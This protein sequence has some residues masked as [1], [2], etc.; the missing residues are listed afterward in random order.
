MVEVTPDADTPPAK[1]HWW[2]SM[3]FK[4][5]LSLLMLGLL[6]WTTDLSD[7]RRAIAT[8]RP[9]WAIAAL[10][11]YLASMVVSSI[12]WTM[13]ARPLGF[14]AP[15]SHFFGS[16]FTGMYMNLFAPSTVAG[17]ISR[18]LF[19]AGGPGR[20]ALALTTVI[21]DRGLG[22]VVLVW[23]G[24]IAIVLQPEYRLPLP[25]YYG[26]WVVPPATL[27]AW[28]YL[29]KL[30]VRFFPNDSRWRILVEKDLAPYW[31]DLR[32]LLA[33]SVVAFVF[34]VMQVF[35]QVLLAWSLGMDT[36]WSYFF[37]FVPIVNIVGMVPI[38]F[39]G[40]GIREFGYIFFLRKAGIVKHT[41]MALGLLASGMVIASNLFGGL[42]FLL[43]KAPAPTLEN[44][45]RRTVAGER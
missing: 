40:V 8:A 31:H 18:A 27:A 38:S 34:H 19:I 23:I 17:D 11:C 35:S 9:G 24:A 41:A 15:Y 22:F 44:S 10:L 30:V 42:V 32:L 12:R 5:C 25:I 16:Y 21:A 33:T 3:W 14:S 13:L 39:G 36:P 45:R 7:L 26:A 28:L 6:F 37:I 43:W 4:A 29:P 2:S 1:A 20:R